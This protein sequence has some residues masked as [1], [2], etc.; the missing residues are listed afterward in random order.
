VHGRQQ[1]DVLPQVEE[2][3]E[4]RDHH[5]RLDHRGVRDGRAGAGRLQ[6]AP[7][8]EQKQPQQ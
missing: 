3:G 5:A 1:G 7:H 8:M 2:P 6:M 4:E